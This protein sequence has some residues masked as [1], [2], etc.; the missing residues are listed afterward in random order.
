[1]EKKLYKIIEYILY[2]Y[3]ATV[4]QIKNIELD[5]E[6]LE[7]NYDTLSAVQYDREQ[8]SK[9]YSFSSEVENKVLELNDERN[10]KL[11]N[12]LK[13]VKREKEI[14]VERAEVLLNSLKG[15]DKLLIE[16]R[17]IE[18]MSFDEIADKLSMSSEYLQGLR[19]K[20][21]KDKLIPIFAIY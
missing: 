13:N 18:N 16:L 10:I 9:T 6:M 8:L 4:A 15:R 7:N 19:R 14:Q 2:N 17:Y 5:I 3:N 1:M 11:I 20:I 21:I 12:R